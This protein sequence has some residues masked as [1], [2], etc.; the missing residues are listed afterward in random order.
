MDLV[1]HLNSQYLALACQ[2]L[3]HFDEEYPVTTVDDFTPVIQHVQV[4]VCP[5]LHLLMTPC[6]HCLNGVNKRTGA[7]RTL[8]NL[9]ILAA[10]APTGLARICSFMRA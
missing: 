2:R 3:A 8:P 10:L 5:P 4:S 1:S 9:M 7:V 6:Q